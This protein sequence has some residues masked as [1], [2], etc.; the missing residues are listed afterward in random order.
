MYKSGQ[1]NATTPPEFKTPS[2]PFSDHLPPLL[3]PLIPVPLAFLRPIKG[4][5]DPEGPPV[6]IHVG[7]IAHGPGPLP[8]AGSPSAVLLGVADHSV[9]I[10]ITWPC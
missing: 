1:N 6:A 8:L 7:P 10:G 4:R 9:P 2:P 3:L 5:I